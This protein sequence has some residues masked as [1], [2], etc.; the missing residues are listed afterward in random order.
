MV[1]MDIV[2]QLNCGPTPLA[3][4]RESAKHGMGRSGHWPFV[5]PGAGYLASLFRELSQVRSVTSSA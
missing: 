4:P 1:E 3:I 2:W 5:G